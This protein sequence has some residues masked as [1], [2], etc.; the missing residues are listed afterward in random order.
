MANQTETHSAPQ[1]NPI[2]KPSDKVVTAAVDQNFLEEQNRIFKNVWVPVCH[3]SELPEPY[4]FRTTSIANENIIICR[5]PDGK[6]NALLNVCPHRGM[7][8]ERRPQ[9]SFLEGQAS[10]IRNRSHACSTLGNLT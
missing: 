6:V 9:G 5:A 8:I 7:L 1:I 3:E 4:D 10:G 2:L